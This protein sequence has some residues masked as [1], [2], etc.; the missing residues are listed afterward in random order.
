MA[1]H[2]RI[3][4]SQAAVME[5]RRRRA[6]AISMSVSITLLLLL[7][8]T[9]F[10]VR[11][12][13]ITEPPPSF[14]AY[15]PEAQ[16]SLVDSEKPVTQELSSSVSPSAAVTPSIIIADAVSA[17]TF[18]PQDL[19]F[20][21]ADF[22]TGAD[23]LSGIGSG[24]LPGGF[25]NGIGGGL[26]KGNGGGKGE[27]KGGGK[28]GLNDDIQ[29]VI[30]LDASG[31]MDQLF[32]IVSD[33]MEDLLTTLGRSSIG[34]NKAK[35]NVGLVCYG[36]AKD[37]G[38]PFQLSPFSQDIKAMRA[39]L[40]EVACDGAIESCGEAIAF[41]SEHFP[42]NMRERDDML[43]VIFIAGNE[44][45]QQGSVDYHGAIAEATRKN[46]IVNTIHCGGANPE[47]EAAAREG[48]GVGFNITF[49]A[50][51]AAQEKV[52][53]ED[54]IEAA[55]ALCHCTVIPFGSPQERK[56]H[57]KELPGLAK[58]PA[59]KG[60]EKWVQHEGKQLIHGLAWDAAEVCRREGEG[61]KLSM[62]GGLPNLPPDIR[63]RGEDG[64]LDA[65][66]EAAEARHAAL[67]HF[68]SLRT[69]G[70]EFSAKAL[71]V[72][73]EQAAAKGIDMKL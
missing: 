30:L 54:I 47:W 6:M 55:K 23:A 28:K 73:Q 19:D 9:L 56:A 31:S 60:L 37:N 42:W 71:E 66:V 24:L 64:A 34:G 16:D 4:A 18:S 57:A 13:L 14:I 62:V 35:V 10:Y 68:N 44:E 36:Q 52:S 63:S 2:V 58:G 15:V 22:A 21:S 11:F 33:A 25:G 32:T 12:L 26:G 59:R 67:E 49:D 48:N 40:G 51:G 72:I 41:A 53:E 29:I 20:S 69:S 17:V 1:I 43:K 65:I 45:F 27:G 5:H 61:F 50:A 8:L 46:I 39:K 70:N 3:R 7:T 38:K